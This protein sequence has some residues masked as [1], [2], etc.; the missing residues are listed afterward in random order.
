MDPLQ[1]AYYFNPTRLTPMEFC[2]NVAF[3]AATKK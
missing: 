3:S 2:L 1:T